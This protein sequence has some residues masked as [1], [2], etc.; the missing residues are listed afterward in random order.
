MGGVIVGSITGIAAAS[1]G[2]FIILL[3]PLA[4]LYSMFQRYYQRTNMAVARLDA[5]SRSPIY[6]DFSQTLSGTS[7][8]RA[9]A[10]GPNFV[11]KL[12]QLVN[13]NAVPAIMQKISAQWLAIRLDLLGALI[14]FFM[15][16]LAVGSQSRDN[17]D[18]FIPAGYLALGLTY[19]I[20]L[21]N[22]LKMVVQNLANLETQFNSVERFRHYTK[23]IPIEGEAPQDY[24]G[25]DNNWAL[26]GGTGRD[27]G[28]GGDV[29][30][31][32]VKKKAP[33]DAPV[34][35]CTPP[36][37]WPDKGVIE[38]RNVSLRYRNGPLVLKQV[39]FTVDAGAKVGI[40]GRTG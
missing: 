13:A 29:E 17:D 22:I 3:I 18:S 36:P 14:M 4:Y 35:T 2:T 33:V 11:A 7:T 6:A 23:D 25:N 8:V 30:M 16:A 1:K 5:V 24:K 26:E 15:G 40:C 32:M 21:T 34:V 27:D 9:Y 38:F 19:S 10:Q 20:S 39:S 12:E 31:G 28:S 37:S